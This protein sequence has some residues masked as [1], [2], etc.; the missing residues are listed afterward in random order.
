MSQQN[1]DRVFSERPYHRDPDVGVNLTEVKNSGLATTTPPLG[2]A[3]SVNVTADFSSWKYDGYAEADTAILGTTQKLVNRLMWT[4]TSVFFAQ[5]FEVA[6]MVL[7][8]R[9]AE[10]QLAEDDG[11]GPRTP[12]GSS[13]GDRSSRV[14][15]SKLPA[16]TRVGEEF[17]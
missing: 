3:A 8:V 12:L 15:S 13:Y 11:R 14:R 16:T 4:Y 2:A 17:R 10:E 6:K 1:W 5:P 7:Q 9:N